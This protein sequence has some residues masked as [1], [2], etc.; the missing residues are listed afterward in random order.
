MD[1]PV[2]TVPDVPLVGLEHVPMIETV[3]E[4]RVMPPGAWIGR[5]RR[6]PVFSWWSLAHDPAKEAVPGVLRLVALEHDPAWRFASAT[7][8]WCG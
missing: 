3:P 7:P 8:T 4:L 5:S 2:E 6:S 1:V